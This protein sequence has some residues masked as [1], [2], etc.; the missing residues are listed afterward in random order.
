MLTRQDIVYLNVVHILLYTLELNPVFVQFISPQF[1]A[2]MYE[3]QIETVK[4][5]KRFPSSIRTF[6]AFLYLLFI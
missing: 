6:V 1:K 3:L 4:S 2:R 5:F